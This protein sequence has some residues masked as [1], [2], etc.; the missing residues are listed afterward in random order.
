[1]HN[2]RANQETGARM[3]INIEKVNKGSVII[4]YNIYTLSYITCFQ[5]VVNNSHLQIMFLI[6][7][8]IAQ[9]RYMNRSPT[10]QKNQV[11]TEGNNTHYKNIC[12]KLIDT[13]LQMT[14][15]IS[16]LILNHRRNVIK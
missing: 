6:S 10:T 1:M 5:S 11:S 14:E 4:L 12:L 15:Y 13:S 3:W 8:N 2:E 9:H 7:V 16:F